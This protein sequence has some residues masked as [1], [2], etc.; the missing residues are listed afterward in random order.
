ML[1]SGLRTWRRLIRSRIA[2]GSSRRRSRLRSTNNTALY[3]TEQ[4]ENRTLLSGITVEATDIEFSRIAPQVGDAV[5]ASI[6]ISNTGIFS[7]AN[8][9][10][11]IT[12]FK[13]S[14]GFTVISTP[15]IP[16]IPAGGSIVLSADFAIESAGVYV[17]QAHADPD[18]VITEDNELDNVATR[19]L[20]VGNVAVEPIVVDAVLSTTIG[21]PETP[22]MLA[23]TAIYNV[24]LNQAGPAAGAVV[25]VQ[26]P[27]TTLLETTTTNANGSFVVDFNMPTLPGDYV[28]DTR[29][30]DFTEE[31]LAILPFTVVLPPTGIDLFSRSSDIGFSD[32]SPVKGQ[33]ITVS[34]TIF[35]VGGD[36]YN[37]TTDV[38]FFDGTT[39]IGNASLTDLA[40]GSSTTVSINHTLMVPGNHSIRVE[41]DSND[42]VTELIESNNS[43]TRNLFV[44]DT[45]PELRPLDIVFSDRTP[46][47]TQTVTITALVTNW[48]GWCGQQCQRAVFR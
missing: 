14:S 37:G 32:G 5:T 9:P 45:I 22:V 13:P 1:L 30:T 48:G 25:T 46:S 33:S 8:V 18:D 11:R 3:H 10:V 39:L 38:Q 42:N 28:A 17:L 34:A 43:A 20:L 44:L 6:T 27:G 19:S 4:L 24:S 35:N 40:A 7:T 2:R 26:V 23:G 16:L 21:T 31:G 15:V 29:V 41:V 12:L 47:T 36:D